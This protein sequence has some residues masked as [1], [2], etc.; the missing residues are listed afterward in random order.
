MKLFASRRS[1]ASTAPEVGLVPTLE[2][3]LSRVVTPVDVPR[4][5]ANRELIPK[6]VSGKD[7]MQFSR[8]LAA[9]VRAGI[10]ILDGL[11]LLEQDTSNPTLKRTLAAMADSLR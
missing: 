10:P 6:R 2:G 1:G 7:L 9:F 4:A 11:S 8:Q 3:A 5:K